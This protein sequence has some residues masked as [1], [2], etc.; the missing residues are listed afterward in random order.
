MFIRETNTNS[1]K[2]LKFYKR[3]YASERGK[4]FFND[5]IKIKTET[6]FQL[7][8]MRFSVLR[9]PVRAY[10]D[11]TNHHRLQ[12][13]TIPPPLQIPCSLYPFTALV[14][15]SSSFYVYIHTLREVVGK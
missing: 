13:S 14:N 6:L 8:L 11:E 3:S 5:P 12:S 9:H 7:Y 1:L 4:V 2:G 15:G 10:I